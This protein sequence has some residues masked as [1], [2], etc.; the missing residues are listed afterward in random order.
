MSGRVF[1]TDTSDGGAQTNWGC[2]RWTDV[3]PGGTPGPSACPVNRPHLGDPCTADQV[4]CYYDGACTDIALGPA[5]KCK[6][7]Y[8][9]PT[10]DPGLKCAVRACIQ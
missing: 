3:G 1:S 10:V 2:R 7:G 9:Y 5:M 8:W 4:T 6:Q